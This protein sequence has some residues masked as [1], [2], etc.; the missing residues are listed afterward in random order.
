MPNYK[1]A[2][3]FLSSIFDIVVKIRQQSS[4]KMRYLDE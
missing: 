3:T 1:I 2:N 4:D